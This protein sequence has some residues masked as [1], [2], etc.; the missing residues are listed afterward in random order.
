MSRKR[1]Y[2]TYILS[3]FW[4]I[5]FWL[6]PPSPRFLGEFQLLPLYTSFCYFYIFSFY[7]VL[8]LLSIV[9]CATERADYYMAV[10]LF[11]R[12]SSRI[13][14]FFYSMYIYILFSSFSFHSL[15]H[16]WSR[17]ERQ[18][19]SLWTLCG[20]Q[21]VLPRFYFLQLRCFIYSSYSLLPL[22]VFFLIIF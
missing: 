13:F 3:S 9:V 22:F 7:F 19:V 11:V 10:V 20:V 17:K 12:N 5:F 1:M 18:V 2:S 14:F 8:Y 21:Q 15:I 4:N 16:L 6:S